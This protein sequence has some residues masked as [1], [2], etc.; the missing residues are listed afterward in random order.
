MTEFGKASALLQLLTASWVRRS[1]SR[2]R[3]LVADHRQRLMAR[4]I[5]ML[6]V[7]ALT[8]VAQVPTIGS[9]IVVQG[10]VL[11]NKV[12]IPGAVLMAAR[13]G[14]AQRSSTATD[15]NGQYS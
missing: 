15:V 3:C 13:Q 1:Y 11:S 6:F 12:P 5:F 9:G 14:S 4:V 8:A 7:I 2:L 10:T